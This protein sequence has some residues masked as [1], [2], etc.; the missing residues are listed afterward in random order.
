MTPEEMRAA[1]QLA[2]WT[3][4]DTLSHVE[5]VHRAVTARAFALTAPA[6]LPARVLH[7]GIAT[8]IYAVIRGAG[9]AAGLAT[10]ELLGA[11]ARVAPPAGSTPRSNLALGVLN[12]ILGDELADQSSPLAIRMAVRQDEQTWRLGGT[13]S[14]RPFPRQPRRWQSS[15]TAWVKR[16]VLAPPRGPP[17]R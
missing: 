16:G 4:A 17:R 14:R 12:A 10:S 2:T 9:L 13:R 8:G 5:H 15:F 7:D 1:G 6:S 11:M 3:L